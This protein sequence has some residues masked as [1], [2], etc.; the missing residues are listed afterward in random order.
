MAAG[1]LGDSY[2]GY[3]TR[4]VEQ[5]RENGIRDLAVLHA[6]AETPRHLFVP[7]ALRRR[8]Y[9]D[10]ALPIGSGQTI[11]QPTTQARFLEALGLGGSER[12]LE[13]G[14]GSGYQAALLS[15]LVSHV[16]TVER[17]SE[18]AT[19][20]RRNLERAHVR[21][22]SVVTGD[23]SVG[24]APES[25]YNAI[26]V[27][28]ASPAIPTPLEKQLSEGGRLVIPLERA[29]LQQLVLIRK[30]NGELSE[31]ELGPAQFVPLVGKYGFPEQTA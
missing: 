5:L 10:A 2:G 24:W 19:A 29:G 11:S 26:L 17:V 15:L 7:A 14:T 30:L 25:P 4:L 12:V 21:A 23:G 28:A 20:A 8:A 3:R 22:V 1:R 9:E 18:L 31:E 27:A 6:F 16:V 13:K